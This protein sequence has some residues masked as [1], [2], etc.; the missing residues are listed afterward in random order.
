MWMEDQQHVLESREALSKVCFC[1]EKVVSYL[2]KLI[3]CMSWKLLQCGWAILRVGHS[4]TP[5]LSKSM[6]DKLVWF[7]GD[8]MTRRNLAPMRLGLTHGMHNLFLF[9]WLEFGGVGWGEERSGRWVKGTQG[10]E[11][12]QGSEWLPTHRMFSKCCLGDDA[13]REHKSCFCLQSRHWRV[14][15]CRNTNYTSLCLICNYTCTLLEMLIDKYKFRY[16]GKSNKSIWM[17]KKCPIFFSH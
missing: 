16:K 8:R 10:I 3:V 9:N 1:K 11:E 17:S 13:F 5:L 2:N 4:A 7:Q 12:K 6:S 15:A 14:H